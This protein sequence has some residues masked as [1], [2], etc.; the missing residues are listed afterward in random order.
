MTGELARQVVEQLK[1]TPFVLAL[2]VINIIVLAGFAYTLHQ[3]SNAMERRESILQSC[4]ERSAR[5]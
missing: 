3:V 1:G 5:P 2:L 4:I